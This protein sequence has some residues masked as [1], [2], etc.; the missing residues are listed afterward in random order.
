MAAATAGALAVPQAL[1]AQGGPG[2]QGGSGGT[3]DA[4]AC[5]QF[6]V[7]PAGH[8]SGPGTLRRPWRTIGFARDYIRSHGLNSAQKMHCD[9]AVNL[10]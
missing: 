3:G 5:E 10:L 9:I 2:G 8:D 7:S 6:Y 1:A 4:H